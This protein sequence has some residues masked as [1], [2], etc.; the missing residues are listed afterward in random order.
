MK[1]IIGAAACP[2]KRKDF[3]FKVKNPLIQSFASKI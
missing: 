2:K 1:E 3:E